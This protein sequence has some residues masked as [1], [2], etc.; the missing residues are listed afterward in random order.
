MRPFTNIL[1][2]FSAVAIEAVLS[3]TNTG[4]KIDLS[5]S[6]PVYLGSA[7]WMS[8]RFWRLGPA[9]GT[10]NATVIGALDLPAPRSDY[11]PNFPHKYTYRPSVMLRGHDA[12]DPGPYTLAAAKEKCVALKDCVGFTFAANESAPTGVIPKVFFKNLTALA[13]GGG[14]WHSY[15]LDFTLPW[16][17]STN[18][19]ASWDRFFLNDTTRAVPNA[20]FAQSFLLHGERLSYIHKI[21]HTAYIHTYILTYMK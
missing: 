8:D 18:G 21:H 1:V 20:S 16:Y 13:G 9:N 7:M 19:G 12:C 5:F 10:A 11:P 15:L 3:A 17:K 6:P 14:V 2:V 4:S